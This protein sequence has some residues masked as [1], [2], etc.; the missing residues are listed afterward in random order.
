[1]EPTEIAIIAIVLLAF[2]AV[3]RRLDASPITV[4]MVFVAA[5]AL[6]SASGIVV[7]MQ[8]SSGSWVAFVTQQIGLGL[9]LV[10]GLLGIT[11]LR[12]TRHAGW[13]NGR[14]E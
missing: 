2:T 5:G 11:V 10:L 3:S 1:M 12:T 6:L 8:Q 14:Y 4:P 13:P 9:G 7:D